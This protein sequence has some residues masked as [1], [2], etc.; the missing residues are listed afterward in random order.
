M[1]EAFDLV[2]YRRG[3]LYELAE[4]YDVDVSSEGLRPSPARAKPAAGPLPSL[5]PPVASSS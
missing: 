1:L 5:L 4:W 2:H 3:S